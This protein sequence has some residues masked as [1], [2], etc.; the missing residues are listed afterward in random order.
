MNVAEDKLKELIDKAYKN[1][2]KVRELTIKQDTLQKQG[3]WMQAMEVAKE[4][5]ALY[6]RVMAEALAE[7]KK[8]AEEIDI[9]DINF[10]EKDRLDFRLMVMRLLACCDI[11]NSTVMDIQSLL[12]RY[13][14]YLSY[15]N[16]SDIVTLHK[17][18]RSKLAAFSKASQYLNTVEWGDACDNMEQL[19]A[20][21]VK[22]IYNKFKY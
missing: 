2:T 4:L 1:N 11:I 22:K 12:K 21:K 13:D 15:D 19:M 20:N 5:E 17:Y 9:G 6:N 10:S 3:R 8:Y 14:K 18:T 7:A 16:F